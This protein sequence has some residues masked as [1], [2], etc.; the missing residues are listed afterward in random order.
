MTDRVAFQKR[1]EK[2]VITMVKLDVQE[3]WRCVGCCSI[4]GESSTT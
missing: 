1:K 2:K 3:T 4:R